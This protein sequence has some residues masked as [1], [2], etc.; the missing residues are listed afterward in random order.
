THGHQ[1]GDEVLQ[2]FAKVAQSTLRENDVIGRW[3]GEEFLVLMYDTAPSGAGLMALERLRK[4]FAD[5]TYS[6]VPKLKVTFSCGISQIDPGEPIAQMLER[7][8][9]A[10]YQAK[11][12]G[13]NQCV[14]AEDPRA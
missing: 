8:D 1:A 5:C 4:Y 7:V 13:R 9:R 6:N 14:I 12:A 10:L 3:G 2:R 11:A